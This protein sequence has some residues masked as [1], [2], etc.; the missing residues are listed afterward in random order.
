M[1][2]FFNKRAAKKAGVGVGTVGLALTGLTIAM[3]TLEIIFTGRSS[4]FRGGALDAVIKGSMISTAAVAA[5]SGVI[6]KY[7]HNDYVA[8][9]IDKLGSDA[10]M[11]SEADAQLCN[12][13][14][15][16]CH[17]FEDH[18]MVPNC[19]ILGNM[20]P[21]A[22][23]IYRQ[24]TRTEFFLKEVDKSTHEMLVAVAKEMQ[25]FADHVMAGDTDI[26]AYVWE[27][28]KLESEA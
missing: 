11:L 12:S 19:L 6:V 25:H 15:Y 14:A 26:E 20:G 28:H 3:G 9:M 4:I 16:C 8:D 5:T 22:T 18:G 17:V 23:T 24:Y 7:T 27:E 1:E 13:I 10:D 21:V 2:K